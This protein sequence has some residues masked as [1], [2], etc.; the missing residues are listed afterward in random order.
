MSGTD[1]GEKRRGAGRSGTAGSIGK[2]LGGDLDFEADALLDSLLSDDSIAPGKSTRPPPAK[3][4]SE[5]PPSE[6]RV[7][8]TP[9]SREYPDDEPTWVGNIDAEASL[10]LQQMAARMGLSDKPSAEVLPPP[11][12]AAAPPPVPVLPPPPA[13]AAPRP[14][15]IPR[16]GGVSSVPRPLSRAA[17]SGSGTA[18]PPGVNPQGPPPKQP[19]PPASSPAAPYATPVPETR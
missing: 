5:A 1:D 4:P 7:L 18:E 2:E 8:H 9:K 15:G 10:E 14:A 3:A 11:R 16:P 19:Y 13:F 17:T 6:G 12:S